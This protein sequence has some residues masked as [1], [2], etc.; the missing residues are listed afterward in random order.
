MI[1]QPSYDTVNLWLPC[2][3]AGRFNPLEVSKRLNKINDGCN[4]H[5][6]EHYYSGYAG[7]NIRVF[8]NSD[9]ISLKGSLA[10]YFFSKPTSILSH[11]E[12]LY[13]IEKLSNELS[14]PINKATVR[15][16]DLACN[17][18]TNHKPEAYYPFLGN[19]RHFYREL[20]FDE[21]LYYKQKSKQK[22]LTLY[23]KV[24]E[25][26][27]K[28]QSIPKEW[29][30]KNMMRIELKYLKGVANQFNRPEILA[31]TLHEGSFFLDMVNKWLAEYEAIEKLNIL[32]VNYEAMKT[33]KDFKDHL[34]QMKINELGQLKTM[35][36]IEQMRAMNV[37]QRPESYSRLKSDIKQ[38]FNNPK[39]TKESELITELN[40]KVNAVRLIL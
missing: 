30:G 35:E 5:T 14:L 24:A 31:S 20:V 21:S 33:P 11:K 17:I 2:E 38:L 12:S 23:D 6:G 26:R 18:V 13:A 25:L 10:K 29:N 7:D 16:I 3:Q 27:T 19:S 15:R 22:E 40:E 28:Q 34:L 39:Q 37:M 36:I 32:N 9:G 4:R 8:I 1:T